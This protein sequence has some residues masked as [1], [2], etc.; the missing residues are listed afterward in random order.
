MP[1]NSSARRRRRA[2]RIMAQDGVN[3]A[4]AL[5][6]GDELATQA[7]EQ[8]ERNSQLRPSK[9]EIDGIEKYWRREDAEELGQ[10]GMAD[11]TREDVGAAADVLLPKVR[12]LR[13]VKLTPATVVV[14]YWQ[15]IT[16][17]EANEQFRHTVQ[18]VLDNL[19]R[20]REDVEIHC[21]EWTTVATAHYGVYA[22]LKG[23]GRIAFGRLSTLLES[24]TATASVLSTTAEAVH[25]RGCL[26]GADRTRRLGWGYSPCD[27]SEMRV[28]VRIF[29]DEVIVT[30]PGCPRHA[31]EEIVNCDHD[32]EAGMVAVEVMG[33]TTA[34]L[35]V[36]YDLAEQVR[37]E[38]DE[39]R[40]QE[41]K[42]KFRSR[43][44]PEPPW[45]RG[46]EYE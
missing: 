44:I 37:R 38:R 26:L 22:K 25:S 19:K 6:R 3:Y 7:R 35:D 46:Q 1:K 18:H 41:E 9:I 28:R 4:E 14:P 36:I 11:P 5:L 45:H 29:D 40:R 2:R 8:A 30:E 42:N 34:D 12:A 16:Q 43:K 33:G 17:N 13:S 20:I 32:V 23:L 15:G 31:A 39:L 10:E 21:V 27:G 24:A